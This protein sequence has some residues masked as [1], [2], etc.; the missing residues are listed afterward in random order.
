[1][2]HDH[3]LMTNH[4]P[5]GA[6]RCFCP[7][8]QVG[9]LTSGKCACKPLPA[10]RPAHVPLS[11][12]AEEKS[13]VPAESTEDLDESHDLEERSVNCAF[14]ITCLY[15]ERAVRQHGVCTCVFQSFKEKRDTAESTLPDENP[16]WPA[17]PKANCAFEINCPYM[18]HAVRQNGACTCVPLRS[19]EKRDTVESSLPEQP[20]RRKALNRCASTDCPKHFR[21]AQLGGECNCVMLGNK[22]KRDTSEEMMESTAESSL[23][24]RKVEI[25]SK[26]NC[27]YPSYAGR[28]NGVRVCILPPNK[29]KRDI[30][31]LDD[32]D[33][34][35]KDGG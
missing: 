29:E 14:K 35:D 27:P 2:R 17:A 7:S 18:E 30:T 20:H 3:E 32:L 19:K 13:D 21:G 10:G 11:K 16:H 23:E 33:H 9:V 26:I 1:V 4:S 24:K 15:M 25:S 5:A 6:P 8:G 28:L 12:K 34:E 31:T 22:E